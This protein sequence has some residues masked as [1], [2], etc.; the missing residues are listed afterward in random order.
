M[1]SRTV[2]IITASSNSGKYCIDELFSKYKNSGLKVRAAFRSAEKAKPFSDKYPELE[3]VTDVDAA[4]P[5][6]LGKVFQNADSAL[7]VTPHDYTRGFDDDAE[8]TANMINSAVENGVKYIVLVASFT[9]NNMER[10]S[11]IG[12][13]F[14]PSE[15]LLEKLGNENKV[16]WT[17]LRGGCFM[18]NFLPNIPKVK[19]EGIY[20]AAFIQVPL[21][22]TKDIGKSAAACLA[23][24][25]VD[26]HDKKHYEMNGPEILSSKDMADHFAKALGIKVEY[27][28]LPKE[29]FRTVMPPAV[30]ELL[31]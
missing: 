21:V 26:E 3:I 23:S 20:T 12:K 4:K 14:K 15:D 22:D 16:K 9:V 2:A 7:I 27:K 1:S 5:E 13:R 24:T 28:E 19:E 31:E 25:N 17:V 10:M 29:S 18:E 30:A 11:G 6:T 8:F